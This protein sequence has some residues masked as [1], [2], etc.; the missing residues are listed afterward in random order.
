MN[1]SRGMDRLLIALLLLSS[2]VVV[3]NLLLLPSSVVACSIV[4]IVHKGKFVTTVLRFLTLWLCLYLL[5]ATGRYISGA[6]LRSLVVQG[7]GSLGLALGVSFSVLLV[8][9]G[10]PAETLQAFERLRVPRGFAYAL[11]SVLRLLPEIKDVGS[12]QIALLELK[13]IAGRG[14]RGRCVAYGRIIG[15]LLVLLLERQSTHARSLEARGFFELRRLRPI[16]R[17]VTLTGRGV[18]SAIL[19]LLNAV[20]WCWVA[21]WIS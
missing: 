16:G 20:L 6:S 7:S 3:P 8:V 21:R 11:L 17:G 1:T 4:T 9:T 5:V 14:F 18:I 13:G 10:P 19:L 15:P 12:R 2:G